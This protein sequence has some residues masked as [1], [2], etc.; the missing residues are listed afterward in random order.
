[1]VKTTLDRLLQLAH[2]SEYQGLYELIIKN[3]IL[4]SCNANLVSF[5]IERDPKTPEKLTRLGDHYYLVHPFSK[6][7]KETPYQAFGCEAQS[8]VT[9]DEMEAYAAQTA[10]QARSQHQSREWDRKDVHGRSH[11][12]RRY[13]LTPRPTENTSQTDWKFMDY[14]AVRGGCIKFNSLRH[15]SL[16][17]TFGRDD[18]NDKGIGRELR[19]NK[20]TRCWTCN[21]P[22]LQSRC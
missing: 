5:L 17:C 9:D 12:E 3:K 14:S 6:V 4:T 20:N 22:H 7:Q 19:Q 15:D 16:K 13:T 18:N 11:S 21:G 10:P 2:V 8:E 1:M